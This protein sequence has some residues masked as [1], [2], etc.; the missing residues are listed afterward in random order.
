MNEILTRIE[1]LMKNKKWTSYELQK[2]AGFSSNTIFNWKRNNSIPTYENLVKIC[3]VFDITL[4]QFFGGFNNPNLSDDH[5][6]LLQ[7][8]FC[9]SDLEKDT[10][11]TLIDTFL[12]SK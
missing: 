6:E 9:L 10:V 1:E 7:N 3:E 8:W 12:D 5:K 4:E 2:R 11:M